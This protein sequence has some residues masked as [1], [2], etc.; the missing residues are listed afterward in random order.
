MPVRGRK[1]DGQIGRGKR[2]ERRPVGR[3]SD[4]GHRR[5][6]HLRQ[7]RGCKRLVEKLHLVQQ[8][9]EAT[10]AARG[11]LAD[12]GSA[13]KRLHRIGDVV[14]PAR[15]GAAVGGHVNPRP[16][17][18]DDEG[19]ECPH[20]G[21]R[22]QAGARAVSAAGIVPCV[23]EFVGNAEVKT[24][25]RCVGSVE[26]N[27]GIRVL[28]P[29]G[30]HPRGD[31][32]D[33]GIQVQRRN[34]NIRVGAVETRRIAG[35]R[36]GAGQSQNH[37][38]AKT[39]KAVNRV[40][41]NGAAGLI[42]F[43]FRH[44]RR[45]AGRRARDGHVVKGG[46]VELVVGA[47]G[48]RQADV[49]HRRKHVQIRS[50]RRP[51]A[52]IG[53]S[54]AGDRIATAHEP[55]PEWR[56]RRLRD[57]GRAAVAA[58]TGRGILIVGQAIRFQSICRQGSRIV[59]MFKNGCLRA[60][61]K[62]RQGVGHI[63]AQAVADHHAG[64]GVAAGVL[65]RHHARRDGYVTDHRLIDKL[66]LVVIRAHAATGADDRERAAI[67]AGG[68]AA[69]HET[70][71]PVLP[72]RGHRH[73]RRGRGENG[74]GGIAQT[75][76]ICPQHKVIILAQRGHCAVGVIRRAVGQCGH[77]RV[78]RA[79][80]RALDDIAGFRKTN[81]IPMKCHLVGH[82]GAKSQAGHRR[83]WCAIDGQ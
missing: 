61:V 16:C 29:V 49:H 15:K 6:G 50:L 63:K 40:F 25:N 66:K 52:A 1:G 53:R 44:W 70:N 8:A 64:H 45:Q 68:T 55:H 73:H 83:Q 14:R 41:R 65:V 62:D 76:G 3:G 31:G 10:R 33:V 20:A 21:R 39:V 4:G 79:V 22:H 72:R 5:R 32:E 69:L 77:R 75:D 37:V 2:R 58:A 59:A 23:A 74:R 19:H 54:V 57:K 28:R 46:G 11:I 34:R 80:G 13:V 67:R 30:V 24:G 78:V 38:I 7:L 9:V 47:A 60:A 12:V 81:G 26:E 17:R 36:R 48:H 43:P 35:G 71:I 27:S 82:D 18:L 42:Q 51:G 56:A